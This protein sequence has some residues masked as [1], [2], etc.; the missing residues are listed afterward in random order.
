MWGVMCDVRYLRC[1]G[2]VCIVKCTVCCVLCAVCC[3][4]RF[5]SAAADR[6]YNTTSLLGLLPLISLISSFS[7]SFCF[8]FKYHPS[9]IPYR[10]TKKSSNLH[11]LLITIYN[12]NVIIYNSS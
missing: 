10:L 9:I 4:Q 1:E 5:C 2:M 6:Y 11:T 8:K 3:V 12:T 7:L